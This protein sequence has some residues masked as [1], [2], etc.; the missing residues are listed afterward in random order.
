MIICCIA[1]NLIT[2]ITKTNA[3]LI[4]GVHIA[5]C[6]RESAKWMRADDLSPMSK[7]TQMIDVACLKY[8]HCECLLNAFIYAAGLTLC[9]TASKSCDHDDVIK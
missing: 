3:K 9:H 7:P 2:T 6:C 5:C 8:L 4:F 1:T